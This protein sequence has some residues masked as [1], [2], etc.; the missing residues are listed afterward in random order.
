MIQIMN[1]S[2]YQSRFTFLRIISIF[3]FLLALG[4]LSAQDSMKLKNGTRREGKILGL[5]KG[6]IKIQ[7]DTGGAGKVESTVPLADVEVVSMNPPPALAD[8]EK[9]WSAGN[10][11]AVVSGLEPLVNTFSG[12]PVPWIQ[13]ATLLLV[14]AQVETGALDAAEKTLIAFQQAYPGT[15][16]V[17][18][19]LRAKLAVGRKNFVGAKPLLLPIIEEAGKV[20][21]ADTAQSVRFGQAYYLMG[22]IRE[23]EG[24]IPGALQD[25]LYASTIF[26][27]DATTAVKAQKKADALQKE[28]NA[29]VP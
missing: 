14:D 9:N 16:N 11:S 12:L 5:S 25:Y 10:A 6:M 8:A 24:D 1:A 21:L 27:A 19:L 23:K 2:N 7:S 20:N 13:Q 28:K 4:N 22:Q 3:C 29:I 17:A 26:F 18:G 15:E